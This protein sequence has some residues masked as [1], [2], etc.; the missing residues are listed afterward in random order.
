MKI[1][2]CIKQVPDTTNVRINPETN[3]LIREGVE[4]IINPFDM[5]ALE[6]AIRLKEKHGGEVIVMS[7]GPP[8]VESSLKD[9]IALGADQAILLTDRA[10]AGADTLATSYTLAAGINALND[11]DLVIMGKQAIDGDTG[12]VGPGV[13]E[14]LGVPHITDIR[15]IE[16]VTDN[17]MV[18][19]RLLEEGYVR[20]KVKFPAVITVVKEINE[21]RLPSLKGKMKAKSA[22]IL[23]WTTK[24]LDIDVDRLGLTGS[25]T[26]VVRIFTPPKP[27]GGKVYK[28]ETRD[29]VSELLSDLQANGVA[30]KKSKGN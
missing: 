16:E 21:P 12:Q 6:E 25:P 30:I 24:D 9:A 7:M 22:T 8:Q 17:Y 11:A 28:G 27:E 13:A 1:V 18:C 4:S 23:Q 5:Y 2:V 20:L 19:E 26:Q 10:F 15:K 29:M 14:N 3:T